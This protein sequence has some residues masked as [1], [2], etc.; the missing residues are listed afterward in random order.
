M[1]SSCIGC[2]RARA[3]VCVCVCVCA[4]GSCQGGVTCRLGVLPLLCVLLFATT[5]S[6]P[7]VRTHLGTAPG[8]PSAA[9]GLAPPTCQ[10]W[11]HKH[12]QAHPAP[13]HTPAAP[14]LAPCRCRPPPLHALLAAQRHRHHHHHHHLQSPAAAPPCAP[15]AAPACLVP[16]PPSRRRLPRGR[17]CARVPPSHAS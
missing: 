1:R 13:P 17:S 4:L 8:S 7:H 16:H 2:S 11:K 6:L 14:N 12:T 3:R 15:R 9:T 10:P 5:V